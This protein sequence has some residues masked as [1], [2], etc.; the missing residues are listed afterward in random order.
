MHIY[1]RVDERLAPSLAGS[2][3]LLPRDDQYFFDI[4]LIE[5]F[6]TLGRGF[7]V[8]VEKDHFRIV[9]TE[10]ASA[11]GAKQRS[12]MVNAYSAVSLDMELTEQNATPFNVLLTRN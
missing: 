4:S 10:Q 5:L 3:N 12:K 2:D 1:Y 8:I 7:Y 6:W 9:S 11:V